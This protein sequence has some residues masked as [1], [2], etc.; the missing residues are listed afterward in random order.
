MSETITLDLDQLLLDEDNPR[1]PTTVGREQTQMIVYIARTTSIAEI[2]TAI[3]ENDYFPG[4]PLVV[5]PSGQKYIVVEGNRRLTALKLLQNPSLYDK[6]RRIREIAESAKHRPTNIPCVVFENRTEVL[7]YLGYRH[8][9]GVKQWEPLAK[10]RYIAQYFDH[11]TDPAVGTAARYVHVARGIGSQGPYIKRQLDGL[12]IY[13]EIE[14]H[15]FYEIPDLD[16][17]NISFSLLSTAV[18]YESI[19]KFVSDSEH[20][21][22]DPADLNRKHVESLARWMFEKDTQGATVLGD[23]RNIQR[24]AVIVSDERALAS[25]MEGDPLDKAYGLTRGMSEDFTEVLSEAE[26]AITRAVSIIALVDIDDSHRSRISNISKQ[27]RVLRS[28]ADGQDA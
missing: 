18:G 20:P 15:E 22:V 21:Y 11:H 14:Q 7:N 27:V 10:A 25:L 24:L 26:T 28:V 23:S 17:E 4:E 1:L 2:M 13:Q 19:L 12:A 8:I 6:S 5:V 9:T 3:A 16:E